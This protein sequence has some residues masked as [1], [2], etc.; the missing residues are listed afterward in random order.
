MPQ[1]VI[2]FDMR[3]P[4]PG[5]P[6][7]ALYQ[8]ALEM[9][10]WADRAG[11]D[12]VQ[13]SEHHGTEDGYL[14]SPV[15]LA[16]AIAARTE[17]LRIRLAVV[18]LPF[19]HP[20]R[21]AEDIAVLD[22]ISNGRVEAVFGGGYA[23][24]E[25][26]MFGVDAAR[27]GRIME[28]G[29]EAIKRAWTGEEFEFEGRRVR[30]RPTPVQRPRPPIWLGGSSAP[31]ARRA[32]RIADH[33][34]TAEKPLYDIY[35]QAALEAGRDPG[36]YRNIGSG[37]FV[38]APDPAA[39]ARRLAPYILHE[40]NSYSQWQTNGDSG[41]QYQY[42]AITDVTPVL[43]SGLYPILAPA[44]AIAHVDKLGPDD[45]LCLHPLIS[46]MPPEIGWEQLHNFERFVL[47]RLRPR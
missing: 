31:A 43:Q 17:R 13:I 3:N 19:N 39:E 41:T 11:F 7:Q 23:P 28:A 30:V 20:L 33:F 10:A 4:Q 9:A 2:R 24:H 29:V 16:A 40:C 21:I 14:P 45:A 18:T 8:A 15:V 38:V 5:T 1:L 26:A 32:A 12:A 35:R 36:P 46:G 34:Y 42:H 37:F 44:D 22:I 25:F 6:K 27:R 47:P